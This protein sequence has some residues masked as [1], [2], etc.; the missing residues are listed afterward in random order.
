M[1]RI[2]ARFVRKIWWNFSDAA[3]RR[4]IRMSKQPLQDLNCSFCVKIHVTKIFF[5]NQN[6]SFGIILSW[7]HVSSSITTASHSMHEFARMAQ[8][9]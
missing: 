7:A 3:M 5:L 9:S 2:N 8:Q 6:T 4:S 1:A